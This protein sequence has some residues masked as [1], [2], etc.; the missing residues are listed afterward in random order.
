MK[1]VPCTNFIYKLSKVSG[2]Y[3]RDNIQL[4]YEKGKNDCII[5][6]DWI[7]LPKYSTMCYNSKEKLKEL[8]T[9]LLNVV[10]PYVFKVVLVLIVMWYLPIYLDG[11]LL[12]V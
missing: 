9:K 12:L 3:F 5:L 11:E 1:C 4:E 7:I 2:K 8:I 10:C 6:M